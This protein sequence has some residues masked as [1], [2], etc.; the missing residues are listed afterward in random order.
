MGGK[1]AALT[2]LENTDNAEVAKDIAMQV[3]ASNPQ[4]LSIATVEPDFLE[5]E[6]HIK[7]EAVKNDPALANKPEQAL[8]RLLKVKLIKL[9]R[10]FVF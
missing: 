1:I 3:A 9:L 5:K 7:L 6:K 2:V 4:Y 10:K 8:A